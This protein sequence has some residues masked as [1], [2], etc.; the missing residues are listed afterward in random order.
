[1]SRPDAH[2]A[3]YRNHAFASMPDRLAEV[4]HTL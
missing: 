3:N 4:L 1:V 2:A